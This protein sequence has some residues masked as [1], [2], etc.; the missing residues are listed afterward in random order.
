MFGVNNYENPARYEILI[1]LFTCLLFA[2]LGYWMYWGDGARFLM[3]DVYQLLVVNLMFIPCLNDG[4]H[5]AV[6]S[7]GYVSLYELSVMLD[8][9]ERSGERCLDKI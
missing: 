5:S 3:G 4:V 6:A 2:I 9:A 1:I 8:L 7:K